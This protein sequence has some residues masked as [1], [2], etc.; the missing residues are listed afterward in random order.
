MVRGPEEE[1]E[2]EE[3]E[4][5]EEEE[6]FHPPQKRAKLEDGEVAVKS[7]QQEKEEGEQETAFTD[8]L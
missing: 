4:E 1:E 7:V 6:D 3:K 2:T 5:Q 8:G